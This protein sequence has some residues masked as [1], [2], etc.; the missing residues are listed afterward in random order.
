MSDMRP[1][2]IQNA[3][4]VDPASAR[5]EI[6]DVWLKDGL[7]AAI[8]NDLEPCSDT[9]CVDAGNLVLAPG[10]IDLKVKTGEPGSEHREDLKSASMAAA[11]GG[12]TT[13]VIAP[14][15]DPVIDDAALVE[16]IARS[17]RTKSI[18]NVLP[19]GALTKELL[20]EQIAEIGLMAE[21]GAVLFSNGDQAIASAAVMRKAL[22]YSGAFNALVSCRPEDPTLAA[23]GVM[24][25][26][27]LSSRMGLGGIP[28]AAETIHIARDIALAELTGGRLLIEQIS[29]AAGVDMVRE[30]KAKGLDVSASVSVHHLCLNELDVGGY[31]TFA[32]LSPPL[33]SEKDRL[34]LIAGVLDGSIDVIV[35]GH[36]PRPAEEKRLPFAES[37]AGACGLETL[38][39]GA[40]SL[41]HNANG[42]LITALRPLTSAPAELLGINAGKIAIGAPADLIL[43]D[44]DKPWICDA[45]KLLSKSKNTPFDGQR[46]QSRAVATLVRGR[47][48]YDANS[49]FA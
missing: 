36:D 16:F 33:R 6:C 13:M 1:I 14:D 21:A 2:C 12:V 48:V 31:R 35:S 28:I 30:A 10:L 4:M 44:L 5:D 45:D 34:G 8:G 9:L 41:V 39:S 40:L 20:G 15:T 19:A 47:I 43:I 17:S 49:L 24:H 18:V 42:D 37:S 22:A 38:L 11:A 46:M 27:E 23:N 26:G 3:Q 32:R 7:I 25:A 29:S